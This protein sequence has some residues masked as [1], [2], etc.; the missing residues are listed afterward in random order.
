MS[1][2][3]R[4]WQRKILQDA[5][6]ID[7]EGLYWYVEASSNGNSIH[8]PGCYPKPFIP[9]LAVGPNEKA[10]YNYASFLAWFFNTINPDRQW[11]FEPALITTELLDQNKLRWYDWLEDIWFDAI[12]SKCGAIER[13][14]YS[15]LEDN[16]EWICVTCLGETD[17]ERDH[18][19][20]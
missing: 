15:L 1:T 10:S 18:S 9:V 5:A 6:R 8:R 17:N 13:T 14:P 11:T 20:A 12:C 2:Q 7:Y 3:T 16:C 19:T 4:S